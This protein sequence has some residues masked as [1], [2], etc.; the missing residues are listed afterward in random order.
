MKNFL[1]KIYQVIPFKKEVF[2]CIKVFFR[3]PDSI[4]QHLSF[5]GKFRVRIDKKHSFQMIHYGFELENNLF[6]NGLENGWE[7][8][9]IMLW[10]TLCEKSFVIFD[11]GANT[12]VYSLLAKAV[13]PD[14]KVYAF[15]PVKRVYE[16][17]NNNIR[18]NNYDILATE[19]AISNY[20]G[21]ACIY[22][23]D[24]EHIYSVTVN[25][26]MIEEQAASLKTMIQTVTLNDFIKINNIPKIDLIKI[27]VETHEPE[28][29]EGFN[30]YLS[31][32]KPTMLIEILNDEVGKKVNQ[33][34]SNLDY[35]YFNID[36]LNG[37]RQVEK[38][39]K[40]DYYNYL[41]CTKEIAKELNLL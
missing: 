25:K 29:L 26:N 14:A 23:L 33:L 24:S 13:Q 9:S 19:K 3:V 12:G 28:V 22:D 27:D 37:I 11:I 35:Y 39:S 8:R 41:I 30:E 32:F 40:S 2:G 5:K 31:I 1:K 10:K 20:T 17:L 6:W 7:K 36:E 21:E 34:V 38:I 18:L 4:N 15:E 16:K